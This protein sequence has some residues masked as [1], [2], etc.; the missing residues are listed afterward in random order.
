MKNTKKLF[1]T[2]ASVSIPLITTIS[3]VSCGSKEYANEFSKDFV[4]G[5]AGRDNYNRETQTL[6]LSKTNLDIIPQAAFSAKALLSLFSKT[7]ASTNPKPEFVAPDGIVN[8]KETKINIKKIILPA[9]LKVIGKAAFEGLGLEEVQ[10]D[11]SSS[12]LTKI[13]SEAFA[14]NKISKIILP[15]SVNSIEEKAFYNNQIS[16]INLNELKDL[17]KLSVGV[18]ANNKLNNIDLKNINTIE[19]S[20]LALNEFKDLELHK[21][22]SIVSE[23]LFFFNGNKDNIMPINLVVKNEDVKKQLTEALTKNSELNYIIK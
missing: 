18:L 1:L 9:S 20:A 16:F 13:E 23:K 8:F 12:N 3:V 21:D 11:I 10:F 14:N 19:D 5:P 7:V 17:K 2:L 4:L 6:D 22:I 15:I